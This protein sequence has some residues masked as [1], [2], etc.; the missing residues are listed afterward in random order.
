MQWVGQHLDV[1]GQAIYPTQALDIDSKTT[2]Q[3]KMADFFPRKQPDISR[4]GDTMR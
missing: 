2:Q 1:K 3:G 4:Q